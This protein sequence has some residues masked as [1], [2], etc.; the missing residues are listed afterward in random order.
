MTDQ[1]N[2][3]VRK[4]FILFGF[5]HFYPSGGMADAI[6]HF[7]TP[8]ELKEFL[9]KALNEARYK[10][11]IYDTYQILDTVSGIIT[12]FDGRNISEFK[13]SGIKRWMEDI[14]YES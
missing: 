8:K 11:D 12:S 1:K 13:E 3:Q 7:S 2:E 5:W 10:N 14:H 6:L 9:V 4:R